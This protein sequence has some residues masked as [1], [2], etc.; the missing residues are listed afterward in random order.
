M[1][2]VA[3]CMFDEKE[4]MEITMLAENKSMA[5]SE[6]I[7]EAVRSYRQEPK[8]EDPAEVE[9][10]AEHDEK[11]SRVEVLQ[12]LKTK[13]RMS[14][15]AD[16]IKEYFSSKGKDVATVTRA[17]NDLERRGHVACNIP[18]KNG[19]RRRGSKVRWKIIV[20]ETDSTEPAGIEEPK[21]TIR[22]AA[23]L[24]HMQGKGWLTLEDLKTDLGKDWDITGLTNLLNHCVKAGDII[25]SKE[26][27]RGVAKWTKMDDL[28][29]AVK[30]EARA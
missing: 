5:V 26:K 7:M 6:L 13:P 10:P 17:L 19:G 22:K 11:V 8:E 29:W 9:V 28:K 12:F 25:C 1:K 21:I 4:L 24:E 23:L 27:P 2:M 30:E 16:E 15:K 14:A 18:H 3:S 20:P